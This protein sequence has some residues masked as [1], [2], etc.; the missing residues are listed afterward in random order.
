[1]S[2]CIERD[3]VIKWVESWLNMDRYFRPNGKH[4]DIPITELYALLKQIPAADVAPVRHGRW[5]HHTDTRFGPKLNDCIECSRC[6]IWYA[7]ENQFRRT[8]CPNCG[9]KMDGGADDVVD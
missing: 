2:D 5:I 6:G 4:D 8:Y 3:A 7:S 1:M 9:A